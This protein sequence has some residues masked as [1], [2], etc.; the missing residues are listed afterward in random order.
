M[1]TQKAE[2]P[3]FDTLEQYLYRPF[4]YADISIS[5]QTEETIPTT[6][7]VVDLEKKNV[8]PD[9]ED[10]S[11]FLKSVMIIA[12]NP[13][14]EQMKTS[15]LAKAWDAVVNATSSKPIDTKNRPTIKIDGISYPYTKYI[16]LNMSDNKLTQPTEWIGLQSV[17]KD[18][19]KH[20]ANN[21][22]LEERQKGKYNAISD[23]MYLQL[24]TA[25]DVSS[26]SKNIIK[27]DED[28]GRTIT[29][30]QQAKFVI[31]YIKQQK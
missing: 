5:Y 18:F 25:E 23:K 16:Q 3:F 14:Y 24:K 10:N 7:Q 29:N 13:Y 9:V 1:E 17:S 21:K 30:K 6:T 28:Q 27:S 12:E 15:P 19:Q 2:S 26:F 22:S 4:Q 31:D 8:R 20:V 11:R